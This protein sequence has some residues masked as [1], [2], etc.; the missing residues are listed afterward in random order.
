MPRFFL[1]IWTP[2]QIGAVPMGR[3]DEDMIL[4]KVFRY[5]I[6]TS[7]DHHNVDNTSWQRKKLRS[8][9]SDD[10]QH[11]T[12]AYVGR[13]TRTR[14]GSLT[15]ENVQWPYNRTT[16]SRFSIQQE[17]TDTKRHTYSQ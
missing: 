16:V 2:V 4:I 13:L 15:R 12:S 8:S 9:S 10:F 1:V 7:E 5:S 6:M 14:R 17:E 3:Y 11:V